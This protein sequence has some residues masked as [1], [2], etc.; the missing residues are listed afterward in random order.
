MERYMTTDIEHHLVAGM[1]EEVAGIALTTDIVGTAARRHRRR[2]AAQRTLYGAGVVGL[3]GALA[4]V[5]ALG[6]GQQRQPGTGR[7][8]VASAESPSVRLAAAIAHSENISYKVRTTIVFDAGRGLRW[9]TEGAFDPAR[10]TGYL[11]VLDPNAPPPFGYEERL[12]DGVRFV[13]F[14]G[15]HFKQYPGKHDR[16]AYTAVLDGALGAAF[17]ASADPDQL[18]QALRQAK[19]TITQTSAGTYH[20]EVTLEDTPNAHTTLAGDVTLDAD[21]RIAKVTFVQALQANKDG[22]SVTGRYPVTVELSDYGTPV[23]VQRPTD[24]VVVR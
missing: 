14:A 3:A 20:F 21:K 12:I 5:M 23:S 19:A 17:G 13:G 1:R 8:P 15:G 2:T 4:A 18:F 22:Q 6:S 7:P 24:V 11:H 16:L 10:A 9:S